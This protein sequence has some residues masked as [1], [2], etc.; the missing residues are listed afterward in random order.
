MPQKINLQLFQTKSLNPS[1]P[2]PSPPP[3]LNKTSSL[4]QWKSSPSTPI[5]P[6]YFHSW[7]NPHPKKIPRIRHSRWKRKR[8]RKRKH[9]NDEM[10]LQHVKRDLRKRNRKRWQRDGNIS[11]H[12][13]WKRWMIP[14]ARLRRR[15][16]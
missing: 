3:I 5:L 14:L 6:P 11:K 9:D 7:K 1:N 8:I 12:W 13:G 4:Y 15:M 10:Y 16:F 2:P